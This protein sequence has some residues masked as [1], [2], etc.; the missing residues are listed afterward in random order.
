MKKK[1]TATLM[2]LVAL[3]SMQTAV[4]AA[5][6]D[7]AET[8]AGENVIPVLGYVSP[9]THVVTP[10]GEG[11]IYVE[12]P[13]KI[14]FAAFES[15]AGMVSSPKY[16]IS[17]LSQVS[18]LKVEIG[19]FVQS[20]EGEVPLN[21]QLDLQLVSPGEGTLVADLFPDNYS[22]AKLLCERLPKMVDGQQGHQLELMVGGQ[23]SGGFDVELQPAFE[24]TVLFSIAE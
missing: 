9:D 7:Y 13:V 19:S 3:V 15:G 10:P 21:G 12:V 24:M 22:S 16:T 11:E 1:I 8:S 18:D 6:P 17:N 14:L 20:N 5:E 2:A 4:F 23:W